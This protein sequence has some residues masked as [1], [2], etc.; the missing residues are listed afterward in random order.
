[1]LG[2]PVIGLFTLTVLAV[3][4]LSSASASDYLAGGIVFVAS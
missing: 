4:W 2:T 3:L 1:M